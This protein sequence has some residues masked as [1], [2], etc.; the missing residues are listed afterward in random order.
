MEPQSI[1]CF[2]EVF[3]EDFP[4]GL[5]IKTALQDFPSGTVN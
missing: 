3:S 2:L 1:L 5:T 4:G